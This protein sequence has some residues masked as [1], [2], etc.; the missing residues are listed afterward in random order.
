MPNDIFVSCLMVTLPSAKRLSFAKRAIS[1]YCAQTHQNREL[2]IVHESDHPEIKR[3]VAKLGREDIT[4][5]EAPPGLTLG[6]L[7]NLSRAEARGTVHCQWDDDDIFH[8]ERIERQLAALVESGAQAVAL[9]DVFQ[10]FP[11]TRELYWLNWRTTPATVFPG[12]LTC[13]ADAPI[14]YPETGDSARLGEDLAVC[15]QLQSVKGLSALAGAPHLVIYISHGA[16]SWDDG[17][18][19]MLARELGLSAGLLRRREKWIREHL[20]GVD[21]GP[22]PVTLRGPNA[23]AFTLER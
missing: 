1:A 12:T 7:R 4:L 3:H 9:E 14:H 11:A 23:V 6:A 15:K 21:L 18:H 16:N 10:F 20:T 8:P 13:R 17:H 2:V 19:A 22:G 5:V